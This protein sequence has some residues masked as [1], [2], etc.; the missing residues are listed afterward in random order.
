MKEKIKLLNYIF[1]EED[2]IKEGQLKEEINI[3]ERIN[4]IEGLK[5]ILTIEGV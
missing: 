2:K 4:L 1:E 5:K 3:K